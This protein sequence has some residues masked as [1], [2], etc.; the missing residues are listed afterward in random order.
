MTSKE[1][2]DISGGRLYYHK[3]CTLHLTIHASNYTCITASMTNKLLWEFELV[4]LLGG[5]TERVGQETY[6]F[7]SSKNS[8]VTHTINY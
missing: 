6:H 3:T 8:I 5:F 4:E 2:N 1:V 7:V